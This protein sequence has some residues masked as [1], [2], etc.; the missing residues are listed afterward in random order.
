M[1]SFVSVP[2]Y[3]WPDKLPGTNAQGQAASA[4]GFRPLTLNSRLPARRVILLGASNLTRSF[5][6]V[7]ETARLTW[8]EPVEIMAAMGYGRSYV[9]ESRVLARKISGIFS[10]EL[11]RHLRDRPPLPMVALVTDIGNDLLYGVPIDR[12]LSC[13][14]GC[15]ERLA[16]AGATTIVTRLPLGSLERLGEARFRFF[17]RLFFPSSQLTLA[18]AK[19]LADTLDQR[20]TEFAS[21]QKTSVIPVSP[22]W[23]GLDPIHLR[24]RVWQQ[25]W[26]AL[27]SG[28][29]A[30]RAS[31]VAPRSS[32]WRRAY[33]AALAPC[34]DSW[35]GIRCHCSQPSG[36]LND[37]TTISLY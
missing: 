22:A 30:E 9:Q 36:V 25:A 24:R 4:F 19:G 31:R 32:L 18:A 21:R 15:L 27:L 6:I 33:L 20:L 2:G 23:Y 16:D 3:L 28:W 7:V 29:R 8:R 26:P 14:E 11:W 12:L 34:D 10:C 37:G 17:R 35:F 5:S 1:T 13:V